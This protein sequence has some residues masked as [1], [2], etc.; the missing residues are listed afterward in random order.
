[1]HVEQL[2][3]RRV[4]SRGAVAIQP[5]NHD[6]EAQQTARLLDLLHDL[7]LELTL[8]HLQNQTRTTNRR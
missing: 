5:T 6:I 7:A 3:Q 2:E 8:H 4:L 1:M